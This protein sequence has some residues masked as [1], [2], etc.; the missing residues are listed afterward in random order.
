M[1][2]RHK[3][4]EEIEKSITG[5]VVEREY[6]VGQVNKTDE[7]SDFESYVDLFDAERTE[8]EYD[9]MS[10][11]SI[12]EF[13][14][15]MLTQSSI[16]VSQYFQTRDFVECYIQDESEEAADS[17][18]ATEELINRTLNQRHLYHYQKFVRSKNIVHLLGH[19]DLHCW[20]EQGRGVDRFNY[21]VLD[22]RN[23]FSDNKYTYSM[24]EKDWVIIRSEKTLQWLKSHEASHGF[25]NLGILEEIEPPADTETKKETLDSDSGGTQS[26][27]NLVSSTYDILVRYGQF[28]IMPDGKPGIDKNGEIKKTAE[29]KE[30]VITVALASGTGVLIGFHEQPYE[31]ALGNPF[32]PVIRGLCYIHPT[33]DAGVGDAKYASELQVAIDDTFNL[34]ND[35]TKL[36]TLPTLK[37]KRHI[38]EDSDSIYF[39]PGH[40][41]EVQESDDIEEF[42]IADNIQGALAQLGLLFGKMQQ[43]TSIYP[44]TM[45]DVPSEASTTATAIVGAEQRTARRTNY[46]SQTYEYTCLTELYWMIQQM[47]FQFARPDTGYQLMGDRVFDFNPTLDY[48]YKPLS[49]SIETE[50]RKDRKIQQ[51]AT[52]LG[53]IIQSPHPDAPKIVNY[54]IVKIAE[55]MGDEYVGILEALLDPRVP[56]VPP[57]QGSA[58]PEQGGMQGGPSNQYGIDQSAL[59]VAGRE[60][61]SY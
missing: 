13:P 24:Q 21:E 38:M 41:M 49:Q 22:P 19:V 27:D 30:T 6:R 46:K 55:L 54:Y 10:D 40:P 57:E 35:R 36:A 26:Y 14:S 4:N 53:Y 44:T 29:L 61:A 9:W 59:E 18:D 42:K 47:T 17:A 23:V 8:K 5:I 3:F 56:M 58:L 52:L 28:W 16:D 43:T 33:K 32:K 15:H 1:P 31:D 48:F 7:V 11:V 50:E 51:I 34:G 60:G 39:E 20:W 25:F 37:V 12:P 2:K 45:G